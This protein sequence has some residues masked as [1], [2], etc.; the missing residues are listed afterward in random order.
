MK[1]PLFALIMISFGCFSCKSQQQGYDDYKGKKITVGSGG[2]FT[3]AFDEFAVLENGKVF[4][5]NSLSK[6]RVMLGKLDKNITDQVF[7][8]Y[9]LLNISEKK[10]NAPGNMSYFVQFEDGNVRL[11]SV[12]SDLNSTDQQLL[13]FYRFVMNYI[14]RKDKS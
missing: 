7:A 8:N 6:Q 11:K 13:L 14:P 1:L 9:K 5:F 2:G 12:W 4:H 3:G 10:I